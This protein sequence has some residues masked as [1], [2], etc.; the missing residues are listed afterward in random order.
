MARDYDK[1]AA[2]L[3]SQREAQCAPPARLVAVWLSEFLGMELPPREYLLSPFLPRQG[4]VMIHA[5]RGLGKTHV[6]IGI[7][8][9]V[10]S[11]TTFLK[12]TAPVA[13]GVLLIDGEMPAKALQ[14]RIAQ[15][16][17][18]AQGEPKAPIRIITPD[19]NR[20]RGMPDLASLEGQSAVDA[21][22]DES[23]SLIIVDNLSC[24][25]R[26]GVENEAESWLPIQ[27]WALR[28]RAAGRSVLFIHHSG[29]SGAQRG[30][31]RRED[32]LDSVIGLRR[33]ADYN[34]KEGARFEVHYEKTRGFHGDEATAFEAR[35]DADANGAQ[36]WTMRDLEAGH[37]KRIAE[38]HALGMKPFEIAQEV[39]ISR[40]TVYRRL[41]DLG[42]TE[43][44]GRHA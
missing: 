26:V 41:K 25:A 4:L 33:P 31:S 36:I 13:S 23:I 38:L 7:A 40:P 15:A 32:V 12:W 3:D 27:S 39:G 14:D 21:E 19:L 42:L 11:G 34:P 5:P 44:V 17:V 22:V 24:L 29:K 6:S 9:A 43:K 18:A 30:T 1:M 16:V 10:A 37:E 28:H 20:E 2:E 35:L 8:V